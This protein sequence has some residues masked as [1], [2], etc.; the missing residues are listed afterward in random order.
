MDDSL[1]LVRLHEMDDFQLVRFFQ[2]WANNLCEGAITDIETIV[3]GVPAELR[4]TTEF[5]K[6]T[7]LSPEQANVPI[8]VGEAA[9]VARAIL[10]P[11]ALMPEVSP[12]LEAALGSFDD[13]KLVV[14]V[15]IA[16]GLVASVLLI[17]S[18]IEF[19]GRIGPVRFRKGKA[20]PE[21]LKII[22]GS[23]YGLVAPLRKDRSES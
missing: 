7:D 16:L 2:H 3:G 6:V 14:D 4:E 17:V 5:S 12:S 10:E 19:D 23:V 18:T 9:L 8:Q 22:I 11:L 1:L 15:I 21:T 20:D 13:D